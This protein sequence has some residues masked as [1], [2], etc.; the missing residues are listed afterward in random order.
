MT[1]NTDDSTKPIEY[2]PGY[3]TPKSGGTHDIS[4]ASRPF[5]DQ[6]LSEYR[7]CTKV[8]IDLQP[9]IIALA[10]CEQDLENLTELPA[11]QASQLSAVGSDELSAS[12]VIVDLLVEAIACVT[13]FLSSTSAFLGQATR[14]VERVFSESP[15]FISEWH[16]RRHALHAGSV[17]Y[18][19]CYELR[20]FVQHYGIPISELNIN[21]VRGD[22]SGPMR[23]SSAM[24]VSRDG[25]LATRFD[26]GKSRTDITKQPPEID[27]LE[28]ANEYEGCL[29]TLMLD[30]VHQRANDL[31]QCRDYLATMRRVLKVP[32]E[33]RIMLFHSPGALGDG[34]PTSGE[35][36]P[37]GQF[38]WLAQSI[39]KFATK[40]SRS[41]GS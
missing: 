16:R 40:G 31:A 3:V 34:P 11:K 36:V 26:W 18:R 10:V 7:E 14:E 4:V 28:L 25:L 32:A 13:A 30:M 17:G 33:S 1:P 21:G 5:D 22:L 9:S 35:L 2:W 19:I 29:R 41:P 15:T 12:S 27:L 23:F 38:L 8:I 37:E 24:R 6:N 39:S 20:N